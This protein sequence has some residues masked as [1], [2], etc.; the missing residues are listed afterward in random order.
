ML[1]ASIELNLLRK[2]GSHDFPGAA[3]L[4]PDIGVLDLVTV[5]ELLP[6]EPEFVVDAVTNRREIKGGE[7]VEKTRG[8][9]PQA[10]VTEAHVG[11]LGGNPIEILPQ[12]TERIAGGIVET[13]VVEIIQK[14]STHQILK[15]EV[16]GAAHLLFMMGFLRGHEAVEETVTHRKT[17]GGPPFLRAGVFGMTRQGEPQVVQDRYLQR[18][19]I[20]INLKFEAV[21]RA[22]SRFGLGDRSLFSGGFFGHENF[23]F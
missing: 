20:G 10:A 18:C 2:V 3:F 7:G 16:I 1:D 11:F 4:L 14:E 15:T 21:A 17:G 5:A 9:P 12:F 6:K 8:Q 23:Q 19:G 13:G 22:F